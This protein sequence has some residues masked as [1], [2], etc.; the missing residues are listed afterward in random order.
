MR[1]PPARLQ[2]RICPAS[3]EWSGYA[4]ARLQRQRQIVFRLFHHPPARRGP[5]RRVDTLLC[6]EQHRN[7]P[8][9][10]EFVAS[11]S[12]PRV[13][14]AGVRDWLT[15]WIGQPRCVT[16]LCRLW[17]AQIYRACSADICNLFVKPRGYDAV[18]PSFGNLVVAGWTAAR[19]LAVRQRV[20]RWVG[21][22]LAGRQT[23]GDALQAGRPAPRCG[24]RHWSGPGT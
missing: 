14:D 11:V 8:P 5:T 17:A 24:R 20:T 16:D 3:D 18:R 13:L 1:L 10:G 23:A 6:R 22:P 19:S 15:V 9:L 2:F 7:L 21:C 4:L 12:R